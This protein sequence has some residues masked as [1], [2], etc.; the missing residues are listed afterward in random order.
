M[1]DAI[2]T[3]MHQIKDAIAAEHGNDVRAIIAYARRKF[4]LRGKRVIRPAKKKNRA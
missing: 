4:P 2:M 3:E 1:K